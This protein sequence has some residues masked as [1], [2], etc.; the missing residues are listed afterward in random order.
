MEK[1][2]I[3]TDSESE[4]I[5]YSLE[6]ENSDDFFELSQPIVKRNYK[7]IYQLPS[8]FFVKK[9]IN[10]KYNLN[11][12]GQVSGYASTITTS[13][14]RP[15]L[16]PDDSQAAFWDP[17]KGIHKIPFDDRS[18]TTSINNNGYILARYYNNSRKFSQIILWNTKTNQLTF[19]PHG[20]GIQLNNNN[21]V[22]F[23]DGKSKMT[24][25]NPENNTIIP[26]NIHA[27]LAGLERPQ[28]MHAPQGWQI[29]A[30]NKDK[31]V[32]LYKKFRTTCELSLK[33]QGDQ[34]LINMPKEIACE[35]G[36]PTLG[37][38]LNDNNEVILLTY[39]LK[40]DPDLH[41]YKRNHNYSIAIWKNNEIIHEEF[42]DN[43]P[44][45]TGYDCFQLVSFNNNNQVL[46][47]A[48]KNNTWNLFLITL[49]HYNS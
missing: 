8:N 28:S 25:W 39:E 24:I 26:Y 9:S 15:N 32:L 11:D 45:L 38:D 47:R 29:L 4:D 40:N 16:V 36:N 23:H 34:Y 43:F 49:D 7:K 5:F 1:T 13:T 2:N 41:G 31:N 27:P 35:N 46:I 37:A 3:E 14:P 20:S 10:Q 19:G 22:L 48:H 42:L 12:H 18:S 21:M 6:E 44:E 17:F 30:T 33:N